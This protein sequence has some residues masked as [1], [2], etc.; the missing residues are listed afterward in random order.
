MPLIFLLVVFAGVPILV[1]IL[2]IWM[3][4]ARF[5]LGLVIVCVGLV[6]F[7]LAEGLLGPKSA[8][9]L[10]VLA[11]LIWIVWLMARWLVG[12]CWPPDRPLPHSW[13]ADFRDQGPAG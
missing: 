7:N 1:G 5:M 9:G 4:L 3:N 13:S 2:A 8:D 12:Y 6:V 11:A 10:L